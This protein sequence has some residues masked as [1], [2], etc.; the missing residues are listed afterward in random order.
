LCIIQ[1]SEQDWTEQAALMGDIYQNL[2][3]NIAATAASDSRGGCFRER[4]RLAVRDCQVEANWKFQL[5][6]TFS[7]ASFDGW[8]SS[9]GNTLLLRRAWVLQDLVLAPRVLHFGNQLLGMS[10]TTSVRDFPN[11]SPKSHTHEDEL[12]YPLFEAAIDTRRFLEAQTLPTL[13]HVCQSILFVFADQ[14]GA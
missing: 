11:L 5:K 10:R 12:G 1:D 14:T 8:D 2:W 3:C 6:Q 4:H 9:V 13:G 7:C